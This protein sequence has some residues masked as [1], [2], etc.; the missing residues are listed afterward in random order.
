MQQEL[1]LYRQKISLDNYQIKI[2]A[3]TLMVIDHVGAI[4]VT[5]GYCDH[6]R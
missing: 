3:A 4:V 2:L 1:V 6:R 5:P